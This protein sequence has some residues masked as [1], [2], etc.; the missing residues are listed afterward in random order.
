[1]QGYGS[2]EIWVNVRP[3]NFSKSQ[4]TIWISKVQDCEGRERLLVKFTE[5]TEITFVT[6]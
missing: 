6:E 2:P 5:I 4:G 1:M 3:W